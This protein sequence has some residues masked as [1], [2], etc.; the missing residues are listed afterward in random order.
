LPNIDH[1]SPARVQRTAQPAVPRR[2]GHQPSGTSMQTPVGTF[3]P[4]IPSS[5]TRHDP[6]RG[7]ARV[8]FPVG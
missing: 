7:S 3:V 6:E 4:Q 2:H 8:R 5:H 1:A